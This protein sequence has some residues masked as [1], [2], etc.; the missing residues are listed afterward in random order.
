[1]EP[2]GV[3]GDFVP[4]DAVDLIG[5]PHFCA[6]EDFVLYMRVGMAI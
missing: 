6:L 2:K 5:H 4:G 3:E 1:V